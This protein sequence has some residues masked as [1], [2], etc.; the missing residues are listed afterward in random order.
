MNARK[1]SVIVTKRHENLLQYLF[2]NKVATYKQIHRDVF[3]NVGKS[4]VSRHIG[5]LL[6]EKRIVKNLFCVGDKYTQVYS[7]AQGAMQIVDIYNEGELQRQQIQSSA[8]EH[9]VQ[10]VELKK[11]IEGFDSVIRYVTENELQ[12]LHDY[13]EDERFLPFIDLRSD[14]VIE[15]ALKTG[16]ALI[17]IEL[18]LTQKTGVRYEEKVSQYYKWTE[19]RGVLFIA[20][21]SAIEKSVR[22]QEEA[23]CQKRPAKFFYAK[24]ESVLSNSKT[25]TFTSNADE[26]FVLSS[27]DK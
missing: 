23:I 5:R 26:Q 17:P 4:I 15:M 24:L 12:C 7:L 6:N 11:R 21:T 1:P 27:T 20:A 10:L 19:I 2:Q 16:P 8:I 22:E 13:K 14:A 25:I 3:G 9:D 18:E